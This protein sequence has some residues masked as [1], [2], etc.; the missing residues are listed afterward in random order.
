MSKP[1]KSAAAV[2]AREKARAKAEE[3]TRRNEQLIELAAKFFIHEEE[4]ELIDEDAAKKIAE[5][6]A[7]AEAKKDKARVAAASVVEQMVGTGESKKSIGERLGLSGSELKS[8]LPPATPAKEPKVVE[9][10]NE[11]TAQDTASTAEGQASG[12]AA[13]V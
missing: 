1:R 13:N 3:I 5:L 9:E 10:Q 8:F 11:E 4:I 12:V 7:T 6:Q 2:A